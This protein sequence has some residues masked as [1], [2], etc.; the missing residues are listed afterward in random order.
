MLTWRMLKIMRWD[1]RDAVTHDSLCMRLAPLMMSSLVMTSSYVISVCT[2]LLTR[3]L[4]CILQNTH[5]KS[6]Y[7][8]GNGWDLTRDYLQRLKSCYCLRWLCGLRR[9][10]TLVSLHYC[11]PWLSLS[12]NG[13]DLTEDLLTTRPA[14]YP[15]DG[16]RVALLY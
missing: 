12:G 16:P 4:L 10:K 9:A 6:C 5:F 14:R 3:E 11:P 2:H 15:L 1:G 7:I 8:S 13:W